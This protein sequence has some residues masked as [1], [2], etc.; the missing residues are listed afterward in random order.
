MVG[1]SPT[2]KR[3]C[4]SVFFWGGPVF[5]KLRIINPVGMDEELRQLGDHIEIYCCDLV[6][7]LDLLDVYLN[8]WCVG[9]ACGKVFS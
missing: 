2:K 3:H 5:G 4:L 9:R 7:M 6:N 8:F 1:C